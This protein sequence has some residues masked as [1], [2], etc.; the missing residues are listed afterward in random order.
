LACRWAASHSS[1]S[2]RSARSPQVAALA[3]GR[4]IRACG[5]AGASPSH[6]P[7]FFRRASHSA[8]STRSARSPQ[9]AA[10]AH[11]RPIRACGS[12]GASPSHP[13]L[14]FRR[15]SHSA[16]ST[17]SARSPQVAALA[18]GRPTRTCGSAGAS[19]SRALLLKCDGFGGGALP[20][21]P[22]H[23]PAFHPVRPS[24]GGKPVVGRFQGPRT[25]QDF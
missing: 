23:S 2:T 5:S 8:G 24:P 25:A 16:G 9:V 11:G 6:P 20:S 22:P 12:A 10:L 15:A 14:F 4:P 13:P 19:P 18:H 21:D 1:G 3:H 7:L 17:R